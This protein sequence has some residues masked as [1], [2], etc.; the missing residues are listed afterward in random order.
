MAVEGK[1]AT[2]LLR[3]QVDEGGE[4]LQWKKDLWIME[5]SRSVFQVPLISPIMTD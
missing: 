2:G 3:L 5:S 4:D 1:A